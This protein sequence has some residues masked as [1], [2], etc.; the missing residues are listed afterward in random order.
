MGMGA[1]G[2][3]FDDEN[4]TFGL[5]RSPGTA[6]K[7]TVRK[8]LGEPEQAGYFFSLGAGVSSGPTSL[9]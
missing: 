5:G 4:E 1:N 2:G 3:R 8:Q 7:A 6:K 9:L